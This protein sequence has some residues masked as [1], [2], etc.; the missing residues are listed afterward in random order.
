[1]FEALGPKFLELIT[2]P[3]GHAELVWGIV[4]LYFGW[5]ANELTT[6]KSASYR[7][8]IQTGFSFLWAGAH[9]A[10]QYLTAHPTAAANFDLQQFL[11]V[12]VTVTA[13]VI[14]LGAVA[15]YSGVRKRYPRYGSFLG[16]TRFSNYFMITIFP[17]QAGALAWSWQYLLAICIFALPVWLIFD[18]GLA[19]VRNRGASRK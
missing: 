11:A 1:V 17:L 12:N 2:T 7:T 10:V 6:R 4:P 13:L 9:W 16:H 19:G 18:F 8:A 3:F 15:L 5:L 14:G